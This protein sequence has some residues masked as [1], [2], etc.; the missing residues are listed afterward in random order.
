MSD[1]KLLPTEDRASALALF[2]LTSGPDKYEF[3][4]TDRGTT[5]VKHVA[6]FR[7]G[8]F[9]DS[10]GEQRTWTPEQIETM[11]ANFTLLKSA[12][13]LPNVPVRQ[14]HSWSVKD[15][16]GYFVSV[17]AEKTGEFTTLFADIEFTVDEAFQKFSNGTFRSR[18]AE[19]GM[20]EDNTGVQHWPVIMGVAFVDLPAVEGLHRKQFNLSDS[21]KEHVVSDTPK[22]FLF[23]I[24]G[25]ETSDYA[26]VT[27]HIAAIEKANHELTA[28]RDGLKGENEALTA[29]VST[30]EA[31]AKESTTAA[32]HGFIESLGTD[33]K[34]LASQVAGLKSLVDTMND[35]QYEAFKSLYANAPKLTLLHAH[36]GGTDTPQAD[37][38]QAA[39]EVEI[40]KERIAMFKRSG[41]SDD[42]IAKTPT[43]K[44]LAALTAAGAA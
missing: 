18:S 27:A 24:A 6:V 3:F 43:A 11:A 28:E 30:L 15:V 8:Q 14:D 7:S 25:Q 29:R 22:P 12:D 34:V 4:T 9:K 23:K 10:M 40:L 42:K 32:R 41:M 37:Q 38:A 5:I 13:I 17:T 19:V 33:G 44:K 35:E 26:A 16:V 36:A 20:Y 21:T 31:F 2:G 39:G 1:T